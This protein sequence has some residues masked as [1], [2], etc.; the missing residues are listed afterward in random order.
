LQKS[1]RLAEE[2]L[3]VRHAQKYNTPD[4]VRTKR[5]NMGV[6]DADA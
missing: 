3:L 1:K 5:T 4:R 2:L 6:S